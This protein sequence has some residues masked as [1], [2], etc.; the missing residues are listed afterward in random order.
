LRA[1]VQIDRRIAQHAAN[2]AATKGARQLYL[3]VGEHNLPALRLYRRLDFQPSRHYHYR[4]A[5]PGRR[6]Q[7]QDPS[8]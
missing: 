1:E 7:R 5:T 6:I 8:W 3:Q 2:Q 4:V